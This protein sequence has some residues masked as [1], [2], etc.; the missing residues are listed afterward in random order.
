MS[1]FNPRQLGWNCATIAPSVH[2]LNYPLSQFTNTAILVNNANQ[3]R[4][5]DNY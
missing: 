1:D 5:A 3:Y 4:A 2:F